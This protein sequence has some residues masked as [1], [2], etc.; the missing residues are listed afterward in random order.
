MTSEVVV[1]IENEQWYSQLIED[2]KDIITEA[3]FTS[4]WALVEGYHQLGERIV[5]DS[6]YNKWEQ[7]KAGLVLQGLAKDIN[8]SERSLYY[9]IQFYE[10]YPRLDAV[11]EG[12]NI[13]WNKIITKYLPTPKVE[14]TPLATIPN[15]TLIHGDML[16]EVPKLGQFDLII[17][18]PPY[19]VT[20]WEWDKIPEYKQQVI[21]WLK[22]LK[23]ALA[24]EYQFF[25]FCSPRWATDT[26]LIFRELDIP[27]KSRIVWHRRNM[28]MGSDAKDKFID[29]W[30]MVVHSGNT[31]LNFPD[32][33]DSSRFDVQ[34]FAV[35]QTNFSDAK[36]HPTQKPLELI[37]WLVSYGSRPEQKVLDPFAGAGTTGVA[38]AGFRPCVL[39]ERELEYVNVIK[40]R[41]GL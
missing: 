18:D 8:I 5:T 9:A 23:P 3:V 11:P 20:N 38:C 25:W 14:S 39:I 29:S 6:D 41:L 21:Q 35:P 1:P 17:A 10:K 24:P 27:I 26:E 16:N 22:I 13:T 30:E 37:K 36:L 28:S 15:V 2:C 4:R 40:N 34:T 32:E 12:K 7:N 33:W 19:N 31:S